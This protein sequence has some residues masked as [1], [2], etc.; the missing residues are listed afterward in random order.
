MSSK[1]SRW[2]PHLQYI[3]SS[4]FHPSVPSEA[5]LEIRGG[6]SAGSPRHQH[7]PAV[8]ILPISSSSHPANGQHGLFATRKIPPKTHILDYIGE[9]HCDD[10]PHS[11]Y[12]LSLYRFQNGINVGIDAS[13]MGNE[14]RFIN[15]YRGIMDK[16]NA[17]FSDVRTPSGGMRMSIWSAGLEIK[18]GEEI[19]VSYGK[20]WW[21]ARFHCSS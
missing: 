21:K 3:Q 13:A 7:R 4:V 1:P 5:C 17:I 20:G 9:I 18:K 12:D 11:D 6:S 15:D 2:P 8:A 10:R 16:P 14:A 19:V